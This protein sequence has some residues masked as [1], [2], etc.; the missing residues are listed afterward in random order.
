[1]QEVERLPDN[2]LLHKGQK[3]AL[4]DKSTRA[5]NTI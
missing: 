5:F 4:V 2:S 1:M 3:K